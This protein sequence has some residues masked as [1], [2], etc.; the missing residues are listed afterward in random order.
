MDDIFPSA[1]ITVAV[2]QQIWVRLTMIL[3]D[4]VICLD[5]HKTQYKI[6]SIYIAIK[7]IT[8]KVYRVWSTKMS[9]DVYTK[10][11]KH[12]PM[13]RVKIFLQLYSVDDIFPSAIITVAVIPTSE[14]IGISSMDLNHT[15]TT[16]LP[17]ALPY[18]SSQT[19]CSNSIWQPMS[20]P[21]PSHHTS[22]RVLPMRT[23]YIPMGGVPLVNTSTAEVTAIGGAHRNAVE[24]TLISY[25]TMLSDGS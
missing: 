5:Q 1:I 8:I 7:G 24:V 19:T 14:S 21:P 15:V 9:H 2:I 25:L 23:T 3:C 10:L 4:S 18:S 17:S 12:I 13:V 11:S 16:T 6:H 20:L 22:S